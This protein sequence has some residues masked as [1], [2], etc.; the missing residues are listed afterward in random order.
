M[1]K[2]KKILLAFSGG[3]DTTAIVPWL[4]DTYNAEILCYCCDLGN[5]PDRAALDAHAK[6]LGASEL[7]FED[8]QNAFVT[9]FVNPLLRSGALYQDDYLLG[10]AI[11][12]PLIAERVA[13]W[14]KQKGAD[15]IAHGATGKG[16]DQIRFER[17]WAYL[18][19]EVELIAPWK[20]WPYTGR[21]DLLNYLSGKGIAFH[22]E[23][24]RYSVDT[25]LF[26][27]SCEGGV[28]ENITEPFDYQDIYAWT[29][30]PD[31]IGNET[32]TLTLSFAQGVLQKLNGEAGKP[33]LMLKTLNEIGGRHGVGVVD[34]V[35][36]RTNGVKSRG[37][38]ETPGGTLIFNALKALKH[39]C[40]DKSLLALSRT[41]AQTY[42]EK[43]YEGLWHSQARYGLEAFFE[44]ISVTLTGDV[45]LKLVKGQILIASRRSPFSL[46]DEDLVSFERDPH[47]LHTAADGYCRTIKLGNWQ[48]GR[49][50]QKLKSM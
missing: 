9:E 31:Q 14:A 12:R 17:S 10:T 18:V 40:W 48:E 41:L 36:S 3:L 50:Q 6:K 20:I 49:Q 5:A 2:P 39:M 34:L 11:A 8:V 22:A 44:K 23:E 19:P 13:H 35:E 46:Y 1:T 26:H 4:K 27:R 24:K 33:E 7:I 37:V 47:Q 45:T 43:V 29:K 32:T 28:L 38:Y 21:K 15:A 42:A 30:T 16:N 25:N